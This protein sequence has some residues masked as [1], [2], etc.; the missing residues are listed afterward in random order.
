MESNDEHEYIELNKNNIMNDELKPGMYIKAIPIDQ[1]ILKS[2]LYGFVIKVNINDSIYF[3][4]TFM[5]KF[6]N[7]K[8]V[9]LKPIKYNIFYKKNKIKLKSNTRTLFETLLN[10][11]NDDLIK[12]I[13]LNKQTKIH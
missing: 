11:P 10:T 3:N 2:T 4:S 13:K 8:F 5:I 7:N 12:N 6:K 9:T 1:N